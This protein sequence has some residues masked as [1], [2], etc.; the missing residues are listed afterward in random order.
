MQPVSG[1]QAAVTSA[2]KTRLLVGSV[3]HLCRAH[4]GAYRHDAPQSALAHRCV[5]AMAPVHA[6]VG[7]PAH[8]RVYAMAPVHAGS[9]IKETEAFGP[10]VI[11]LNYS[12]T[13]KY[14]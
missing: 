13:L 6:G 4:W 12:Q 14:S 1:A 3:C 11:E 5:H 8:Q 9:G 7:R 2:L 10:G